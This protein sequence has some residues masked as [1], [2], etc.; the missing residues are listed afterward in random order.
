MASWVHKP[1][2]YGVGQLGRFKRG[3]ED[4]LTWKNEKHR[5]RHVCSHASISNSVTEMAKERDGSNLE[6]I[7]GH[8]SKDTVVVTFCS[9]FKSS[10]PIAE[11][12]WAYF[13]FC[14]MC[15]PVAGNYTDGTERNR[16]GGK[17]GG[18]CIISVYTCA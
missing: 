13:G 8:A 9:Y 7:G 6:V 16:H 10:T 2:R 18:G 3:V 14:R 5:K 11:K 4:A 1:I 12:A 15:P 17:H